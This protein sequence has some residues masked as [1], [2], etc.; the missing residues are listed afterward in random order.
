MKKQI[1]P[2]QFQSIVESLTNKMQ[3]CVEDMNRHVVDGNRQL[4]GEYRSMMRAYDLALFTINI[5][6]SVAEENEFS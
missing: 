4:E 6:S 3:S 2:A 1:N 5:H